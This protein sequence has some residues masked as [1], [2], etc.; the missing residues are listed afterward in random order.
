MERLQIPLARPRSQLFMAPPDPAGAVQRSRLDI[1]WDRGH[2]G[3]MQTPWLKTSQLIGA[4]TSSF[5]LGVN[6]PKFMNGRWDGGD[7]AA[8]TGF[9]VAFV[10]FSTLLLAGFWKTK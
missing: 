1:G 6:L 2:I 3:E 7:L 8:L 5:G 4:V 9:S 10:V